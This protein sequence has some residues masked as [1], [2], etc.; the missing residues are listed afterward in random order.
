MQLKL[1]RSPSG[2]LAAAGW[3]LLPLAAIP[4]I[5]LEFRTTASWYGP[6]FHGRKT[7]SGEIFDQNKMTAASRTLPFGTRLTV[8]N[9]QNGKCC[10]VLINDRG[11][12]VRGRGIDLSHEA[13]RRIGMPGIAPV[14][15]YSVVAGGNRPVKNGSR[16]HDDDAASRRNL[17]Q[18]LLAS[19]PSRSLSR[20]ATGQSVR[21]VAYEGARRTVF[22]GTSDRWNKFVHTY[23]G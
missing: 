7:A 4:L 19:R 17:S 21:Y 15:C 23:R 8:Q 11:P 22:D 16:V 6:G 12:Y 13:A 18:Q 10:E 2:F 3:F 1:G 5:E 20:H 9:L 14:L